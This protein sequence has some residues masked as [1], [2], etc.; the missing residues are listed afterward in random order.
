MKP[1]AHQEKF[2]KG[3]KHP[4][5]APGKAFIVHEGGTG[6]TICGALFIKDGRDKNAVVTCPKRVVNK[7]KAELFKCKTYARVL[8]HGDFVK[9]IEAEG[10]FE[11]SALVVDEADEFASPLFTKERSRRSEALYNEI[12]AYPDMP[13]ALL[14]ATPIRS[15]PWNLHTLLTYLGRY[16]EWKEWREAFFTL[17]D[18]PFLP[19]PAYMEDDDWREKSRVVLEKYADIVLLRDVVD[20]PDATYNMIPVSTPRFNNTEE[21]EASAAFYAEHRHEQQNKAEAIKEIGREFRKV[22]VVAFYTEQIDDLV[23]KLAAD[24]PVFSLHGAVRDQEKVIMAAN[25]ADDCYFI[26]QASIGV[27]FDADTFSAV[28]FASMSNKVR[29]YVQMKYRVRRIHNLHP[30]SYN[31]L[32]GGRCDESVYDNIIHGRDFVP[33]EWK[34]R[35][36]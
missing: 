2:A 11:A 30:V 6:K 32:T 13:V 33:S 36:V 5:L 21:W 4:H 23:V 10:P 14:T 7:W 35:L 17:Q 9:A 22:L 12:K 20:L 31:F 1:L 25:A 24:K 3:Y 19:R 8:S 34:K 28:V 15:N 29:D 18:L 27:G 16:I 26:V